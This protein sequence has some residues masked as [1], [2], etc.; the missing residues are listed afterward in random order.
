MTKLQQIWYKAYHQDKNHP[1]SYPTIRYY[2]F[3][4][5]LN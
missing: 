5:C 4:I 3:K 1:N 2:Q